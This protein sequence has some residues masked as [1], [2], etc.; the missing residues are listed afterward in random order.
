MTNNNDDKIYNDDYEFVSDAQ[1]YVQK[2]DLNLYLDL[3]YLN[4]YYY[5]NNN[6]NN[7]DTNGL[8]KN[9]NKAQSFKFNHHLDN[10]A[11]NKLT[12]DN[13]LYAILNKD[14]SNYDNND[15]LINLKDINLLQ[16]NLLNSYQKQNETNTQKI[17]DYLK[18]N[19][20]SYFKDLRSVLN[21]LNFNHYLDDDLKNTKNL[22]SYE[23]NFGVSQVGIKDGFIKMNIPHQKTYYLDNITKAD[24]L[25]YNDKAQNLRN[26]LINN[27]KNLKEFCNYTHLQVAKWIKINWIGLN[28]PKHNLLKKDIRRLYSFNNNTLNE[29]QNNNFNI[30]DAE[31]QPVFKDENNHYFVLN[32]SSSWQ[33]DINKLVRIFESRKNVI[34]KKDIDFIK[35]KVL[36]NADLFY[37]CDYFESN[38]NDYNKYI[39]KP[40]L[41]LE[42]DENTSLQQ[43]YKNDWDNYDVIRI[44]NQNNKDDFYDWHALNGIDKTNNEPVIKQT[45]KIIE[46][47]YNDYKQDE[48]KYDLG[49]LD[50]SKIKRWIYNHK[51]SIEDLKNDDLKKDEKH[52]TK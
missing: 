3:R 35:N 27:L 29:I 31:T 13:Y 41:L 14:E 7:F 22:L 2:K 16:S 39:T 45:K 44:K 33:E 17:N 4:K 6:E 49:S 48:Q 9:E 11:F 43:T 51:E 50:E 38:G 1:N 18:N 30:N 23:N 37:D 26:D 8:L 20:S 25:N 24:N 5:T 42:W 12:N 10:N 36:Q 40:K 46:D 21:D 32:P 34:D 52:K 19:T 28:S 47:I 15:D